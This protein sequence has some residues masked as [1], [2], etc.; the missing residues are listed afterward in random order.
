MLGPFAVFEAYIKRPFVNACNTNICCSCTDAQI[1]CVQ[2]GTEFGA[3]VRPLGRIPRPS[4]SHLP[5][6][7]DD[8]D[9][10]PL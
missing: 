5:E 8:E 10:D 6:G 2:Q 7:Q 3:L 1:V 4:G 9:L